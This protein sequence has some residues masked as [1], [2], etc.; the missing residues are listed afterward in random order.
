MSEEL[1]YINGINAETGDYAL[2]PLSAEQIAKVARGEQ[3]DD[4]LKKDLQNR[5]NSSL[6][7][8]HYGLEAGRDPSKLDESGWGVIFPASPDAQ[9]A[10]IR[11]ALSPLLDLR[12]KQAGPYYKEY[13]GP[14]LGVR[15]NET[16]NKFLER[17]GMGP[18]P[19]N[20][21]KVPYY[22]LIVGDPETIPYSF[23]FQLDVQ[24]AVG[25]I[26]FDTVEEYANYARS[27]VEAE[28]RPLKLAR[29]ATFF[30]VVNPDD[31]ATNLSAENLV[32]PLADSLAAE[33][34]SWT[35][36]KVMKEAATKAK[37]SQVLG[38][39][40]PSLLFTASHGMEFPRGHAK[41][42]PY[43][44]ALL[45]QDW[46]GPRKGKGQPVNEDKFFH[47]GDLGSD[48]NLLG[49]LAFLFACYGAGSP[50]YDDFYR[51]AAKE[52]AEV[53][54]KAFLSKLP[55]RMLG[56]PKGGALAV[57]GHVE[58]AWG[59]SF[60]WGRAGKQL[61]VFESTFKN[62]F[63]GYPIGYALEPFNERYA[64]LASEITS[65]IDNE[66]YEGPRPAQEMAGLWTAN[67][68]ARNYVIIGDPAVRLNVAG[69]G[70]AAAARTAIP[71]ITSAAKAGSAAP[72]TATSVVSAG[73]G[74][75]PSRAFSS[76]APGTSEASAVNYG[77]LGFG[78]NKE[79]GQTLGGALKEFV[80]KLGKFLS[81][82]LDDAA[83]LE[84]ATYTSDNIEGVK[85]EK[86]EFTGPIKL[87]ALTAIKIDGDTKICVPVKDDEVDLSLWSIH[88]EAV[89]QAQTSRA[90]LVRAAISAVSGLTN[91]GNK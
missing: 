84:V 22:L 78:D 24:Y 72:A 81:D 89:K 45:C 48:S 52:R 65:A 76:E 69:E 80:D 60:I 70:D 42:E 35:F 74:A 33:Q 32:A 85:Y 29:K 91:L 71:E 68:D 87:R 75:G 59:Y 12:R 26:H 43:T 57:V 5:Y 10:A 90:E 1:L 58:R 88:T 38:A 28:T 82:A 9:Y 27:V 54:P 77:F 20:P 13:F 83:T 66:I 2:P 41:Q 36:D 40:A 53:A 55:R 17:L 25:R 62:L 16:K 46:P 56:L 49:M 73:G 51:Q 19:A 50:R 4:D 63:D 15:P 8:S 67:N 18:G 14:P 44:G 21:E 3:L 31:P 30:G 23:Q 6:S 61:T 86:G 11:E 37:L 39:E 7:G 47:A 79:G 64:E 34:K